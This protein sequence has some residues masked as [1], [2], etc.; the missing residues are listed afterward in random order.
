MTSRRVALVTV[1]MLLGAAALTACSDGGGVADNDRSPGAGGSGGATSSDGSA[2]T[3]SASCVPGDQKACA[4]PGGSS[5]AQICND[6]GTAY[7]SCFGCAGAGGGAGSLDGG[8]S[9]AAAGGGASGSAGAGGT[10]AVAG[11]PSGPPQAVPPAPPPDMSS[12]VDAV[13]NDSPMLLASSCVESGGNN[14]FL[15][16]VVRRLRMTDDRWG[17]NW[18]RGNV[19]DLSQ[20]VV[21]YHWG[22]GVSEGSTDVYIID[23]IIG[24][25][26]SS[27]SPGWIDQTEATAQAGTIGRWTLAGN[28]F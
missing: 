8:G 5:G 9:G 27:P 21:D 15:F 25:C 22:E 14:E 13:A 28:T 3:S 26:G 19:G 18:K 16:E 20:D 23:I 7:G 24:H 1:A 12:V 11:S 2:G 10:G 4:C 6:A 17:L